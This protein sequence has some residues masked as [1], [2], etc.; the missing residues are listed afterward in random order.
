MAKLAPVRDDPHCLV[1]NTNPNDSSGAF[2][3]DDT[4]FIA[5]GARCAWEI[6]QTR[7]KYYMIAK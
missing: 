4:G 2:T 5:K 3:T 6:T 7:R 1:P